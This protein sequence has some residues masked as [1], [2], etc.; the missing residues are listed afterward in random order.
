MPLSRALT[1]LYKECAHPA[2]ATKW[3]ELH[4]MVIDGMPLAKSMERSP[5]VFPRVY[6]AMV[7]AG[8]AGGFLDVVLAQIS[9]FQ[10]R[11]RNCAQKSSLRW[12]IP[13]CC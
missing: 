12:C 6:T 11:E 3:R 8:E 7:E 2:A 5:E 10:A 1:I 9:D 4:D 13:R